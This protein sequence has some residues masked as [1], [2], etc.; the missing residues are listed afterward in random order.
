[1]ARET[2]SLAARLAAL[3]VA[4]LFGSMPPTLHADLAAL[5][6]DQAPWMPLVAPAPLHGPSVA[7]PRFAIELPAEGRT[8]VEYLVQN[9]GLPPLSLAQGSLVITVTNGAPPPTRAIWTTRRR[10]PWWRGRR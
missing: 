5:F 7:M 9:R 10:P 4:Q 6:P 2:P 8:L 1:M 3:D